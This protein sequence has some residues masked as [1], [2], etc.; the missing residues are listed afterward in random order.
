MYKYGEKISAVKDKGW[1]EDLT[2]KLQH[3]GIFGDAIFLYAECGGGL[4]VLKFI[5]LDTDRKKKELH[6][7]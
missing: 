7:L 4:H 1:A 5:E 3:E 6:L 2:T